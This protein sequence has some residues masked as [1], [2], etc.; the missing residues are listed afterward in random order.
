MSAFDKYGPAKPT[1]Q[2]NNADGQVNEY[3]GYGLVP[4]TQSPRLGITFKD[5][6][7]KIIRYVDIIEITSQ[8]SGDITLDCGSYSINIKGEHLRDLMDGLVKEQLLFIDCYTEQFTK[9][10]TGQFII[11]DIVETKAITK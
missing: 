5:D 4:G 2:S 1:E 10:T 8:S 7:I 3:V 9:P 11:T 6:S